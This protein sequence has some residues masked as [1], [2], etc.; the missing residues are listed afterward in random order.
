MTLTPTRPRC[1]GTHEFCPMP[2]GCPYCED[3][4]REERDPDA[5]RDRQQDR[6][7]DR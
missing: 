7:W 3:D 1:T 5:E 2:E 4:D 6:E